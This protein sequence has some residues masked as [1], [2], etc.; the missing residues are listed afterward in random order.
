[1]RMLATKLLFVSLSLAGCTVLAPGDHLDDSLRGDPRI[2]GGSDAPAGQ[3]PHQISLQTSSGFHFCGGSVI[4]SDWILTA[5]HC[6]DGER[7]SALRVESGIVRLSEHGDKDTVAEIVV[8]PDYDPRTQD[9]DVALLRLSGSTSAPPVALVGPEAETDVAAPGT[10]ATVSGWGTLS[11]GGRSPD[12]LQFVDVPLISDAD[13]QSAYP[14]EDITEHMVCAG[15]LEDGGIDSCQGDSGGPLVVVD[16]GVYV[17]HGVVSWGYGCADADHPGVYARTSTH[18]DW[19]AGYVDDLRIVGATQV[20]VEEPDEPTDGVTAVHDLLPGELVITEVMANPASCSDDV[21]EWVELLNRSGRPV[22]L[23]GLELCDNH[24]C[25]TV[26]GAGI[27]GVAEV[28]VLARS[29]SACAV[30]VDG[31]FSAA[32]SNSGDSVAI[33]GAVELDA[34]AYASADSGISWVFDDDGACE[35]D[36]GGTPGEALDCEGEP[37]DAPGPVDEPLDDPGH[38]DDEPVVDDADDG[39]GGLV[40]VDEVA[41]GVLRITEVMANP[42]ACSD[43]EGEWIEVH[44]TGRD[45]VNLTGLWLADN[46]GQAPVNTTRFLRPDERAVLARSYAACDPTQVDGTFD[47][48]LSNSGDLVEL[49]RADGTVLDAMDYDDAP[50]GEVWV[51]D[52]EDWCHSDAPSPGEADAPCS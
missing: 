41:P 4:A 19:I 49:Q 7:P 33:L 26:Q 21:G 17:Q 30:A 23:A 34:V 44:N 31:T 24:R 10:W 27:L 52:G 22:D 3:F 48:A 28:A 12:T 14:F 50:S 20:D 13:C 47:N 18:I 11:S 39:P 51:R 40:G 1:M 46:S 38:P 29:T 6:V 36:A 35:S 2:V 32:L 5:A 9:H 42:A 15:D 16:D 37:M 25:D 43:T 8:H 45:T